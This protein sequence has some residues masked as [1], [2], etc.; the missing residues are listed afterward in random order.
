MHF[1]VHPEGW[2]FS[3][4]FLF[5]AWLFGKISKGLGRVFLGLAGFTLYFFRDPERE[6]PVGEGIIVSPADGTVLSI[7]Q[8]EHAPFIDGPAQK[9][10]IFLSILNVH[11]NRA[12]I[13]G[14]VV[15][16]H[17]NPGKF[18]PA[19]MDKASLDN[20]Q[21]AIGIDDGGYRVMVKQIAGIV[22]RRIICWVDNGS[23]VARGERFGLIR[24]GSRT[25]LYL[26]PTAKIDVRVGQKVQG[27]AT[28]IGKRA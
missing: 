21:N 5:A 2:A 6:I 12:P 7:E 11:I 9:I 8:V 28:I 1:P 19:N 27:G 18:F 22:A 3:G 26:P 10:S 14:Q 20:E 16:R 25:E 15:W 4:A 17:Y 23:K 24:F 13:E